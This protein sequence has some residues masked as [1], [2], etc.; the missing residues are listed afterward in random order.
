MP[1]ES[2]IHGKVQ[3]K[4][5]VHSEE[6]VIDLKQIFKKELMSEK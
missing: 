1:I 3:P 6:K 5:V 4:N 2:I